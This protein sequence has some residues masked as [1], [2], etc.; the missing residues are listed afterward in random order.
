MTSAL[1]RLC[2]RMG[3]K[4]EC[5]YGDAPQNPTFANAHPYGVT[6]RYKRRQMTCTFYMGPA[7]GHEPTAADVLSC[8]ISDAR[9]CD[10]EFESWA[11]DLGFDR[12][13]RTAEQTFKVCQKLGSK[14]KRLLG[15]DFDMFAQAEH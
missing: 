10:Q 12:D 15:D 2:D 3:V 1:Q 13:S 4:I 9:A 6:L 7:L 8:L 5:R 14:V 11:D